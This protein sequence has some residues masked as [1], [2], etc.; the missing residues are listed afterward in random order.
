[1]FAGVFILTS[2]MSFVPFIIHLIQLTKSGKLKLIFFQLVHQW[3]K[4]KPETA[5][6]FS[7]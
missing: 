6:L 3:E 2:F 7:K 5:L 4:K 1:M